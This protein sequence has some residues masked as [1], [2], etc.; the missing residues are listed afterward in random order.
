T[1]AVAL[2]T[3]ETDFLVRRDCN[4]G[5]GLH[6]PRK[7]KSAIG[8]YTCGELQKLEQGI[9]PSRDPKLGQGKKQPTQQHARRPRRPGRRRGGARGKC[10][11]GGRAVPAAEPIGEGGFGVVYRAEQT[12]PVRRQVALKVL[13]PGMDTRQVTVYWQWQRAEGE[14]R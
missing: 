14:Y 8:G 10:R 12:Q 4:V 5:K 6:P 7:P 1:G 11:G 9:C 13:K 3:G 2:C